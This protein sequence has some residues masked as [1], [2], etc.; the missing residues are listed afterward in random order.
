LDQH[1][2]DVWIDGLMPTVWMAAMPTIGLTRT[3]GLVCSFDMDYWFGTLTL[4]WVNVSS[5]PWTMAASI[6]DINYHMDDGFYQG[7]CDD[8]WVKEVVSI[9]CIGYF[10]F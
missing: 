4:A 2:L 9:H 10:S 1:C 5:W 3:F 8:T 6:N 7:C